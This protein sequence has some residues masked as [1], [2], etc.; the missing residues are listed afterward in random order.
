MAKD[1]LLMHLYELLQNA[2]SSPIIE[3]FFAF[4]VDVFV[5]VAFTVIPV[6]GI[7]LS[8]VYF[9]I[10]DIVPLNGHTSFGKAVYHMR[11]VNTQDNAPLSKLMMFK[12]V[13]RNIFILIPFLNIVDIYFLLS[14]G[15]RL[16]DTWIE[17]DVALFEETL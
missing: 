10:K 6:V 8:G 1:D 7:V 4:V 2:I 5:M 9:L 11:V 3:R 16:I 14:T 17:T 13:V 12:A 15:K